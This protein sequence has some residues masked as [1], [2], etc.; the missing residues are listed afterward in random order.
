MEQNPPVGIFM[1]PLLMGKQDELIGVRQFSPLSSPGTA[2]KKTTSEINKKG[3]MVFFTNPHL[4]T[5]PLTRE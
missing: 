1:Q 2:H 4:L 3:D 5:G